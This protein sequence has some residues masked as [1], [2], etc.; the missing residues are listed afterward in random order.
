MIGNLLN[1]VHLCRSVLVSYQADLCGQNILSHLF[2]IYLL[3]I[4][5]SDMF[6][7]KAI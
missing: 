1:I 2:V 3:Q 7:D 5:R 4:Y 6:L